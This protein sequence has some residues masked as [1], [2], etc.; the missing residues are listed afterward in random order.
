MLERGHLQG[1]KK[2]MSMAFKRE[3]AGL[4]LGVSG[5]EKQ[6]EVNFRPLDG[7]P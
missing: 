6:S 3:L 2:D 1:R 4:V 7:G 5:E